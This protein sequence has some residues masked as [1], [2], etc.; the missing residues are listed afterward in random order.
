MIK[1]LILFIGAFILL[2]GCTDPV[3]KTISEFKKNELSKTLNECGGLNAKYNYKLMSYGKL[4][5][6]VENKQPDKDEIVLVVEMVKEVVKDKPI[7]INNIYQ[8]NKETFVFKKY[9]YFL[10][11]K[12]EK[13]WAKDELSKY[14]YKDFCADELPR[15]KNLSS[16]GNTFINAKLKFD[17]YNSISNTNIDHEAFKIMVNSDNDLYVADDQYP[18]RMKYCLK[19]SQFGFIAS[20]FATGERELEFNE[21]CK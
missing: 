17:K 19:N 14:T 10:D 1:T 18:V 8:Y 4:N 2:T 5:L 12:N 7:Q 9:S 3:N 20:F 15:R 16:E 6:V 21:K 13:H 11:E